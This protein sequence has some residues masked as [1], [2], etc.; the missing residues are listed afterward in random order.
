MIFGRQGYQIASVFGGGLFPLLAVGL[1]TRMNAGLYIA[2]ILMAMA[3]ISTFSVLL[4]AET[5]QKSMDDESEEKVQE[6]IDDKSEENS[7][8]NTLPEPEILLMK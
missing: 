2:L 4:L 6:S 1:L 3:V 8:K 5:F 7:Q